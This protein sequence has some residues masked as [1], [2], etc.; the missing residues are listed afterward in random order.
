MSHPIEER[1]QMKE[2][3]IMLIGIVFNE[4]ELLGLSQN[5][6]CQVGKGVESASK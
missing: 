3:R 1:E 4:K 2:K 5:L 6:R